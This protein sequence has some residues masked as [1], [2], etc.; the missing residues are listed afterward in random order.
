MERVLL[1]AVGGW[2]DYFFDSDIIVK[3]HEAQIV[4]FKHKKGSKK[5]FMVMKSTL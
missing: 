2:M 4:Y 1:R 3:E 5:G